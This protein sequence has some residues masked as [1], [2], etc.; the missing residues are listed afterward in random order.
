[1]ILDCFVAEPVM[2]RVCARPVGSQR[3]LASAN[4]LTGLGILDVE[5]AHRT[6]L[7]RDILHDGTLTRTLTASALCERRT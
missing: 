6:G 4:L 1:M 2:G 3:R 7:P 5:F